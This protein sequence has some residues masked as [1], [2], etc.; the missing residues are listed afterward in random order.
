[1]IPLLLW[2]I[3]LKNIFEQLFGLKIN[4]HKSKVFCFGPARDIEKQYCDLFACE[5]NAFPFKCLGKYTYSFL[6]A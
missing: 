4:F 2:N 1:M 6:K 3:I 5:S